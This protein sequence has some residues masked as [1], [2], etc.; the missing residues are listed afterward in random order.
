MYLV[1]RTWQM[2][3]VKFRWR[4]LLRWSFLRGIVIL[5]LRWLLRFHLSGKMGLK[6]TLPIVPTLCL[7]LPKVDGPHSRGWLGD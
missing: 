6:P 7:R 2:L 5:L 1:I 3:Q 4:V